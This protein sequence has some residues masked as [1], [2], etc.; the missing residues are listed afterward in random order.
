MT[1]AAPRQPAHAIEP[2][3]VERW[4]TRAFTG[5]TIPEDVLLKAFEAARWAP[6]SGN[7]QPWRFLYARREHPAWE[8][9]L[10]T[11][12]ERNRTW[13]NRASAL[14]LVASLK[15]RLREGKAIPNKTHSFDAG[16]AWSNLA[17]QLQLLG[18]STRAMGGF[19]AEAARREFAV[20]EDFH[21]ECVIAAGK[22]ADAAVLPPDF[23]GSDK[24]NDRLPLDKIISE[25]VFAF[26]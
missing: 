10:A 23:A 7:A 9:L 14:I 19:D 8:R 11:V 20:P 4:S 3:F 13:A 15:Q 2:L 22:P 26:T 21:L 5:E 18:W 1:T 24:P 17:H 16:A 6:S 12:N 25:G